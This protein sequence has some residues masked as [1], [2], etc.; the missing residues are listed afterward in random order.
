MQHH[1]F[2]EGLKYRPDYA[3]PEDG[4][5]RDCP[6]CQETLE[7]VENDPSYYG[8]PWWCTFCK[9]QFSEEDLDNWSSTSSKKG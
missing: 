2:E 1:T 3:W 9:W 4:A 6:K 7:I 5:E 8:K